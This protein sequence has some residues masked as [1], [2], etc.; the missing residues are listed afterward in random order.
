MTVTWFTMA[1]SPHRYHFVSEKKTWT[2][3][4]TFCR[5]TFTDLA[6]VESEEDMGR[7]IQLIQDLG[8]STE[9]WIG[10]R[11]YLDDV[12]T[13]KWSLDQSGFYGEGVG[14]YRDWHE[15][16]PNNSG[17]Q[18]CCVEIVE[19]KWNDTPCNIRWPFICYDAKSDS[20]ILVDMDLSWKDAQNYCRTTF[21]DLASVRNSTENK[22]VIGKAKVGER[23][24]IGLYRD[25]PLWKWSDQSVSPFRN[26]SPHPHGEGNC[27][28]ADVANGG[29]WYQ[30][31]CGL[32]KQFVCYTRSDSYILVDMELSWKDAQN[33]CRTN[34][35]D[36]ASVR[37][38]TENQLVI[39]KAK[40]AL[41]GTWIGLYRDC[42]L[43]KWSDYSVSPFRNWSPHPRGE[44]NCT[45]A[46]VANGGGWYQRD[47]DLLKQ[48][49]CY[50]G[51]FNSKS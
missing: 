30:R 14:E 25:C 46:D 24:W 42:P 33:Y 6:T 13:W 40:M 1:S 34:F 27:A 35:T 15:G 9:V 51:E 37:N 48:F 10:L 18:E 50:S 47:C 19:Q 2:D 49:V 29:G 20:Y 26:W 11:G 5:G 16:Q 8:Y 3:A 39:G 22:Q 31:D 44:G 21:T 28:A 4:Q 17:G 41:G 12:D 23:T 45:A 36:L 32:L 38:S 7:L 43:W